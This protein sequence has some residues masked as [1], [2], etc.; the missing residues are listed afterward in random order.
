[1]KL[2][3]SAIKSSST[4][5]LEW[6]MPSFKPSPPSST[7]TPLLATGRASPR[8]LR[9]PNKVEVVQKLCHWSQHLLAV[10]EG[11]ERMAGGSYGVRRGGGG[12]IYVS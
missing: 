12:Y 1:M 9:G 10:A 11:E 8:L 7:M 3:C 4:P 2:F 6:H 5:S